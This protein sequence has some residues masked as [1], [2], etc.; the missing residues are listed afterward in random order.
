MFIGDV[1]QD[2]YEEVNLL[3]CGGNY[4]WSGREG[5]DCYNVTLCGNTGK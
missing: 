2:S 1:G 5:P 3:E 4:G